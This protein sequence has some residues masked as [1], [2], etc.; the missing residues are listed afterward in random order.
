MKSAY[1]T[2]STWYIGEEKQTRT[3]RTPMCNQGGQQLL[4]DVMPLKGVERA[5]KLARG[6]EYASR[7]LTLP[8]PQSTVN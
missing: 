1:F 8:V 6:A 4:C 5:K 2:P 7:L 3:T